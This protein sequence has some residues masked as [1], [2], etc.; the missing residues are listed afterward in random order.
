MQLYFKGKPYHGLQH[1]I[2]PADGGLMS[3]DLLKLKAG[4]EY[5][6][7]SGIYEIALVI[8][9]GKAEVS[10]DGQGFKDLGQRADVFSGR[11][12]TVYIP[13]DSDYKILAISDDFEAAL[14]HV[15][16]EKKYASFVITPEEVVVN[17][18]GDLIWK[19]DVHDIIVENGEGKVDRI[20]VGE[21][22][23]A[24][25]NWSSFPSHKHDRYMPGQETELA[26]TYHFRVYPEEAFGIQI[27]YTEDRELNEAFLIRDTDTVNIHKGYHP[28]AAPPS[29]KMYYLWFMAGKMG[30]KL[31]PYDDP[32]FAGLRK[33]EKV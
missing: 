17:Y 3:F 33:L 23:S 11:A 12:T 9:S 20:V 1:V 18:R 21:T 32:T 4:E 10:V 5:A 30:R 8:L 24:P 14:C 27:L 28:V 31:M 25:G 16:A 19:R 2:E 6:Q 22:Y 29:V 7:Q 13:R 26:E 15:E